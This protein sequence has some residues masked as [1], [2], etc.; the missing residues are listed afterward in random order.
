MTTNDTLLKTNAYATFDAQSLKNMII[1][2]LNQSRVF[3]DQNYTGS[4]INAIIEILAYAFHTQLFY[5]NQMSAEGMYSEASLYE[6]IN[7]IVKTLNYNPVGYQTPILT[8]KASANSSLAPGSYT[9]PRYSY[10]TLN[11]VNYSFNDDVT[12][13]KTVAGTEE[14]TDFYENTT[15]YQGTYVEY[16]V[17]TAQGAPY[18]LITITS[19]DPDGNNI[20]IDHFNI[21]VY[22]KRATVQS[23]K[24]E[25]F[26]PTE[27]LFLEQQDAKKYEI[28]L[29]E[30]GRYE[31]KF[32]NGIFGRQL[33]Q[34]DQV[35]I[36]FLQTDGTAGEVGIGTL[37]GNPLFLY[38]SSQYDEI[39]ADTISSDLSIA[40][41]ANIAGLSFSNTDPSTTFQDV[42]SIDSIRTNAVN[43]F[44]T[45]FRLIT[46]SDFE[47]FV[48][49]NFSNIIVSTKVINNQEFI[50]SHLKYYFDIGIERPST[51]S[52]LMLNQVNFSSSCA[53]NN[54]Y[55]YAVPRFQKVTSLATRT[56]YLNSAQKQLII[57]ELAPYKI[58]TSEVVVL[59]PVYVQVS[60]G[61]RNAG[62]TLTSAIADE[63]QLV[64]IA[65]KNQVRNFQSIQQ[66]VAQVLQTY[67]KTTNDN[68]GLLI[69]LNKLSADILNIPGVLDF[70]TVR[71]NPTFTVSFPG[72][73][74]LIF[75]P[76]YPTND[77]QITQQN[78][79][80]PVFKFPYLED[81]S[82]F[83]NKVTVIANG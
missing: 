47:T 70:R 26:E 72:L 12:F 39:L 3:T 60:L 82:T 78:L 69:D 67:F 14:L 20:K 16:P 23:A 37:D 75:N 11:G 46:T 9:L 51:E 8:F 50:D 38:K 55:V 31:I 1:A 27:S 24:W 33:S 40:T 80:L 30:S 63:T 77:I 74:L 41:L 62:E 13:L 59:D 17:Y 65:D 57:N 83:I 32:G 49:K 2:R 68:L 21:D 53:F 64:V 42:E 28:R 81:S 18:E 66:S 61:V 79:Q 5:L 45:Q 34:F 52:R 36:Y 22:V 48:R 71:T 43:T 15:L 10:L 29:N 4:N 7:K 56:N 44:K 19:V 25:K 58:A 54:V 73:S 76:V 35:A 6:S